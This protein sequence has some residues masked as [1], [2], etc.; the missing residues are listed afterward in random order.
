MVS[1]PTAGTVT[2]THLKMRVEPTLEM[3][4]MKY[5]SDN[6]WCPT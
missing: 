4:Y 2:T 6:V 5:T 1:N 3:L